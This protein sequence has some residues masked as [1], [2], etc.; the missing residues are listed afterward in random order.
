MQWTMYH[1][2]LRAIFKLYRLLQRSATGHGMI[3]LQ[4]IL[5]VIYS[6]LQLCYCVCGWHHFKLI[7][8]HWQCI[9]WMVCVLQTACPSYWILIRCSPWAVWSACKFSRLGG[10]IAELVIHFLTVGRHGHTTEGKITTES[11][12]KL[13]LST[14]HQGKRPLPDSKAKYVLQWGSAYSMKEKKDAIIAFWSSLDMFRAW[15]EGTA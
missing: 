9:G 8:H 1:I 14:M 15:L 12:N 13:Y 7:S 11:P 10:A 6:S 4:A 5:E 2:C 3:G